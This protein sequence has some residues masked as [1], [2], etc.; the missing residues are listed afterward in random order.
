MG[1]NLH[2]THLN[3]FEVVCFAHLGN[4]LFPLPPWCREVNALH[5][6][7]FTQ[8]PRY[9]GPALQSAATGDQ[10]RRRGK[11]GRKRNDGGRVMFNAGGSGQGSE[12]S[13]SSLPSHTS[14]VHPLQPPPPPPDRLAAT[15]KELSCFVYFC[16]QHLSQNLS[17]AQGSCRGGLEV[18][19]GGK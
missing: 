12:R 2:E 19:V 14:G 15:S 3:S 11:R 18:K 17:V 8:G 13:P 6:Y 7:G 9:P 1:K 16:L 10:A 4:T 5:K